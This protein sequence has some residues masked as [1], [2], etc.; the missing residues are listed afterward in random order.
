MPYIK[1]N[2]C[3]GCARCVPVCPEGAISMDEN[4][5]AVIDQAKCTKCGACLESCPF[6]IIV[7]NSESAEPG[8]DGGVSPIPG[9][10]AG[11]GSGRGAGRGFGKGFGQGAGRGSGRGSGRGRGFGRS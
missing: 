2:L 9:S 1:T 10:G 3:R 8:N 7:P 11:F 5:K 6:G 4:Y